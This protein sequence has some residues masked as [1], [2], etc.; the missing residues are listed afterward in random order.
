MKTTLKKIFILVLAVGV[1][2]SSAFPCFASAEKGKITVAL[3]DKE[4]NKINGTTVHLCQIAELNHT[5]YYPT[6]VFE[7]SGISISGIVN[8]PDETVAN[9][10]ADYVKKNNVEAL[11]QV[12]DNGKVF[13]S[14]LDLGIWLVYCDENGKYTFNPYIVF[15][16]YESGGKLYYEVTSAPKL[17][18]NT[19]NEINI[20]VMKKWDDKNNASKKRPGSVTVELLNGDS[21]VAS[22]VLSE[23]NGWAHTFSKLPK[24]GD[25]SV[26]E[27][28]VANY[29]VDYSGD[30][31]NG[32][33]V[34]NT[35]AG[36]KLPQTGQYWWPVILIAV[37]GT[38]FVLLGV[39]EIGAKKNDKKK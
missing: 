32:F 21:V 35:Y 30:A 26:R 1:L 9:T 12:S 7:N 29:K 23:E 33:A 3:E 4:K 19:P 11:S 15:L 20:Y 38:C 22:I 24:N 6:T 25:Y 14:D 10:I 37:A 5:G 39:Y 13:F 28:A 31:T 18:D 34:T 8:S 16:P 17:E 36:E 2:C 27:K